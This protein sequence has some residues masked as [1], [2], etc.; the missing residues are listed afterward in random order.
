MTHTI[1]SLKKSFYW[2]FLLLM[3]LIDRGRGSFFIMDVLVAFKRDD[4]LCAFSDLLLFVKVEGELN[5]MSLRDFLMTKK[6]KYI[7]NAQ[8]QPEQ[9]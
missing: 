5:N 4:C 2:D 3:S 7:E 1:E 6:E 9:S 8:P